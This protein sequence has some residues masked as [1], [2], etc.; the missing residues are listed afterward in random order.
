MDV[1]NKLLTG[2]NK[3]VHS[4]ISKPPNKVNP[5]TIYSV[6]QRMNSLWARVLNDV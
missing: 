2:Y 5:S 3:S 4:T 1:I 6:W